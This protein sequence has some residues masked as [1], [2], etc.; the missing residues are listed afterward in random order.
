MSS[1]GDPSETYLKCL[2]AVQTISC[3]TL[4]APVTRQEAVQAMSK[5]HGLLIAC[6]AVIQA[7]V[8]QPHSSSKRLVGQWLA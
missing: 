8:R 6:L 4:F 2:E 1:Q 7:L 5:S 3:A